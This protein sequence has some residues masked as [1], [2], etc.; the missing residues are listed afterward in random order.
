MNDSMESIL[1]KLEVLD[2]LLGFIRFKSG[3][4]DR[5]LNTNHDIPIPVYTDI[6]AFIR[7]RNTDRYDKD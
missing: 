4:F 3:E 5:Y 2:V 6:K 7:T 1:I